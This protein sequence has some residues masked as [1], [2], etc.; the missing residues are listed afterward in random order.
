VAIPIVPIPSAANVAG[1]QTARFEWL[2]LALNAVQA[3]QA[4]I[5]AGVDA[6][7]AIA[8]ETLARLKGEV[9]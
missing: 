8:A 4:A 6:S 5:A 9:T 1:N 7:N 2:V 3:N